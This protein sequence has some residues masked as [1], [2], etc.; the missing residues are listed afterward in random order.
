M[1]AC[2]RR[3]PGQPAAHRTALVTEAPLGFSGLEVAREFA[4]SDDGTQVPVTRTVEL[5][6]RLWPPG[7]ESE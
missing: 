2:T 1:V 7:R 5:T 6:V 4:T 3:A